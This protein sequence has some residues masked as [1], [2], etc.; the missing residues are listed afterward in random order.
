MAVSQ[1][2]PECCEVILC[3]ATGPSAFLDTMWVLLHGDFT[4]AVCVLEVNSRDSQGHR[5]PPYWCIHYLT[6]VKPATPFL[7]SLS[8]SFQPDPYPRPSA[9]SASVNLWSLEEW[10]SLPQLFIF[11]LMPT[12]MEK[13][14]RSRGEER[15][16]PWDA[17]PPIP[18]PPQTCPGIMMM[19][20]SPSLQCKLP[21]KQ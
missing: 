11:Q 15:R 6:P 17:S 16:G 7:S 20:S 13:T 3:Y 12:V 21:V 4:R 1:Q 2:S 9:D 8:F 5:V 14:D 19:E 18:S 10:T